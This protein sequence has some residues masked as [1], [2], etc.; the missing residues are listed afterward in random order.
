MGLIYGAGL[1]QKG[2]AVGTALMQQ[3]YDMGKNL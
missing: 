3:A 2:Y 1:W